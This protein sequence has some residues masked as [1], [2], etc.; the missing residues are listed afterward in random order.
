MADDFD[1]LDNYLDELMT[2]YGDTVDGITDN[3]FSSASPVSSMQDDSSD[4]DADKKMILFR[5]ARKRLYYRKLQ[6]MASI[7]RND[8]RRQ[9][10][11]AW[12]NVWN[13]SDPSTY[14]RFLRH[15]TTA[16]CV[17]RNE[18]GDDD[19]V[20]RVLPY[21][22]VI[23][24]FEMRCLH[25]AFI[26]GLCDDAIAHMIGCK[27]VRARTD[28]I[29]RIFVNVRMQGTKIYDLVLSN[30]GDLPPNDVI[31]SLCTKSLRQYRVLNKLPL[32][33]ET[34]GTF[35]AEVDE[36]SGHIISMTFTCHSTKITPKPL[37]AY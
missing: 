18:P 31:Q 23:S 13:N 9:F 27:I 16:S 33:I 8:F 2:M 35:I 14:A 28:L 10:P 34:I 15:Y 3:S 17:N 22:A 21:I 26:H 30:T 36:M 37:A 7:P 32:F 19:L 24:S 4:Q 1:S 25:Y 12:I 29:S 6:S 20:H 11:I 5:R